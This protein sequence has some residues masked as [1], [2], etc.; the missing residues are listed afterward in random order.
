VKELV[1]S[2]VLLTASAVAAAQT[3]TCT[4]NGNTATC[5]SGPDF[6]EFNAQIRRN[7][8][9][10]EQLGR[11]MGQ[12]IN[13]ALNVR[14]VSLVLAIKCG[15]HA[16]YAVMTYSNGTIKQVP[17]DMQVSADDRTMIAATLPQVR[18]VDLVACD[19]GSNDSAQDQQLSQY[20]KSEAEFKA[21][22][23]A[24][25]A[26]REAEE[27]AAAAPTYQEPRD[28]ARAAREAAKRDGVP[29][30]IAKP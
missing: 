8:E 27:A 6:S 4:I 28:A 17:M 9:Q 12:A 11:Q 18:I 30:G 22:W 24:R 13:G 10:M 29:E 15:T 20:E 7:R 3:T 1:V 21:K 23:A 25:R 19:E 2:L 16:T 14:P 26:Q 5:N